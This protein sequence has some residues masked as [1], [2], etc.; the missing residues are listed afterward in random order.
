MSSE[1]RGGEPGDERE[2]LVKG[3]RA[4][5]EE[6]RLQ[7]DERVKPGPYSIGSQGANP[8]PPLEARASEA[9]P[10]SPDRESLNRLWN[11]ADSTTEPGGALARL[12]SPLRVPLRRLARFALGPVV[13]R[14]VEMNSAQVRFDNDLVRYADERFDRLS[15]HYDYVLGLHG[16]RMEEIDERHLILQQE[17]IRHVHDLVARIELVFEAA[18]QNHLYLE[19]SLRETREELSKIEA[20]LVSLERETK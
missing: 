19:G 4:V 5:R 16:R 2:E 7:P 10:R 13:E 12:F 11:V 18:E 8:L 20:R 6:A 17:L 9:L 15:R 14:Q 3:L 1:E